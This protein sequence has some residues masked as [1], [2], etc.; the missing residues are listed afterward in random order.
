[1]KSTHNG[2]RM[3]TKDP[4]ELVRED[5]AAIRSDL[6]SLVGDRLATLQGRARETVSVATD[7][8]Q[9]GLQCAADFARQRAESA[10]KQLGQAAGTHP[11]TT[12]AIAVAVG[13]VGAGIFGWMRH[14]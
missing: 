4:L 13:A 6:A 10:H 11:L 2:S 5:I 3:R 14:R 7:G 12:I 1:M 8:L 9:D